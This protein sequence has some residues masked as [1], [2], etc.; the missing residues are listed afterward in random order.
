MSRGRFLGAFGEAIANLRT[1]SPS[2]G[3]SSSSARDDSH[4]DSADQPQ[5]RLGL[6]SLW[7][8]DPASQ[9]K[10]TIDI[11]AVHGLGGDAYETWR[12]QDTGRIWLKD[13]LPRQFEDAH[14]MTF[15]YNSRVLSKS[16][17]GINDYA[18]DL[19]EQ[20]EATRTVLDTDR[21]PVIFALILAH[22]RQDLHENIGPMVKGIM[23]FGTP[24]RGSEIASWSTIF[25][26]LASLTTAGQ[27]RSDL[28]KNLESSS[29]TLR[30]ISTQ[31]VARAAGLQIVTFYEQEKLKALI[32][33][34]QDSAELTYGNERPIPIGAN[35][36]TMCKFSTSTSPEYKKVQAN[37]KKLVQYSRE[38]QQRDSTSAG[39]AQDDHDY[40]TLPNLSTW[41]RNV[42]IGQSRQHNGNV[43]NYYGPT[44]ERPGSNS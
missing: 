31:F 6:H 14:I 43:Y 33:V 19:L 28:L 41:S 4:T 7:P 3:R 22:E 34:Q 16:I 17:S 12:A 42:A 20:L 40:S 18:R 11:V 21:N 39:S 29:I 37:M 24:H 8:E 38:A 1:P 25:S 13:F 2:R 44:S 10:T 23:F 27:I 5:E 9:T 15:G 26:N 32:I 35:H 36:I 30:D